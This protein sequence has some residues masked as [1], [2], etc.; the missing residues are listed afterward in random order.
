M[1]KILTFLLFS[2]IS[3]A[4]TKHLSLKGE[5][6]A[7]M[8]PLQFSGKF[9]SSLLPKGLTYKGDDQSMALLTI[10]KQL[11]VHSIMAPFFKFNYN[12]LVL[13]VS[14]I[15]TSD[16]KG[17]YTHLVRLYLDSYT[18][19]KG[20]A[21]FYGMPK[22][23][24][25]FHNELNKWLVIKNNKMATSLD[26]AKDEFFLN[27]INFPYFNEVE[28]ILLRPLIQL[29]KTKVIISYYDWGLSKDLFKIRN[30]KSG[31]LSFGSSFTPLLEIKELDLTGISES[32]FGAF[33]FKST[34]S[35]KI[36]E[37]SSI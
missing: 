24:A 15:Y 29:K 22:E 7:L 35:L 13:A 1:F 36:I 12:E 28:K 20:G 21:I 31:T 25:Y 33:E 16:G 9:I 32:E 37:N 2:S 17:P 30:I 34:W 3:F 6:H 18:A 23:Q 11:N 4:S 27:P 5:Y 19:I 10:G 14:N 8:V 26:V